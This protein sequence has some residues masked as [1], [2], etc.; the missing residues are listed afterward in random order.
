MTFVRY[1]QK[2]LFPL[3]SQCQAIHARSLVPCFDTPANKQTY[4]AKVTR[5]VKTKLS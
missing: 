3:Y 4:D 2:I 1:V 5:Y